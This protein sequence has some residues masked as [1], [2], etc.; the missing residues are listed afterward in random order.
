M[1]Q[2]KKI[3]IVI[4][5][6]LFF[7]LVVASVYLYQNKDKLFTST[8]KITYPDRCV[9]VFEN[10]ELISDVCTFGRKIYEDAQKETNQP[11][12]LQWNQNLTNLT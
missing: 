6:M 4:S 5:I 9:E 7:I 8:Y 12:L 2:T 1:G 3:R 11:G 10:D